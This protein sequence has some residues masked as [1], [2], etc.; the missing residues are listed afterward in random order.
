MV[1]VRLFADDLQRQRV[2]RCDHDRDVRG[3]WVLVK[4]L[5]ELRVLVAGRHHALVM[6]GF[7]VATAR[8]GRDALARLRK[9]EQWSPS[10]IVIDVMMPRMTGPE[11]V[12]ELARAECST[13]LPL[14]YESVSSTSDS[15]AAERSCG[16]TPD[17]SP[18]DVDD[19]RVIRERALRVGE[20]VR[21]DLR[22]VRTPA[23]A[24]SASPTDRSRSR[25]A[26]RRW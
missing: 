15:F 13:A 2:A 4:Q 16:G 14:S 21:T 7:S 6:E 18:R 5:Q 10:A 9:P 26:E 8:D 20:H 22:H 11:F 1:P 19:Q 25:T 23:D 12:R 3:G 17:T 24:P